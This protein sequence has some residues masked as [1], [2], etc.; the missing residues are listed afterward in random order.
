MKN[1]FKK[2]EIEHVSDGTC[3]WINPVGS[4]QLRTFK[5]TGQKEGNV[6][7]D[8]GRDETYIIKKDYIK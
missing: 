4:I 1:P 5:I 8:F 2:K 6:K 7:I 3:V